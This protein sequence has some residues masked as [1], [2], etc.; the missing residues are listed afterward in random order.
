VDS[1]DLKRLFSDI[2]F[3]LRLERKEIIEDKELEILW[4]KECFG[5]ELGEGNQRNRSFLIAHRL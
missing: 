1:L 2:D 5:S 4:Y 3:N